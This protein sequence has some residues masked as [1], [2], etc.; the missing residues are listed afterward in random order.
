MEIADVLRSPTWPAKWPF[1]L[2]NFARS[3]EQAD[4]SFYSQPRICFHI[5]SFAIAALTKYYASLPLPRSPSILDFCS[6][7]VSH[8]P[9]EWTKGAER[10]A[11]MGMSQVELSKNEVATETA[12]VDLNE[13]PIFPYPDACFD[14]VTCT[15]SI[16]YLTRPRDVV[17]E[18]GRVLR[19][20]GRAVFSFSNRCFPT[21]AIALWL[22][23]SDAD[24]CFIV[25]C[26]Y[27]YADGMF[28]PP[29]SIDIS[30][31]SMGLTDP[32]YVVTA[33]RKIIT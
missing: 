33:I 26:Y 11:V 25:G 23:T 14:M 13:T 32:M 30:P 17:R 22:Q 18:V 21:K 10:I 19:P 6:S 16:D 15:V 1:T 3:D 2:A 20:G 28:E 29:E 31:P 9:K 27:H 24:H 4:S 12:V 8:Y 7:W 5:D